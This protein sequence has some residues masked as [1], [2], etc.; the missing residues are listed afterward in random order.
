MAYQTMA[1]Q[2]GSRLIIRYKYVYAGTNTAGLDESQYG[3]VMTSH[4]ADI[5][6][7]MRQTKAMNRI[8]IWY[9]VNKGER[10]RV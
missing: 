8:V 3:S 1:N 10:V 9:E 6:E 7:L 2:A 5:E 4:F